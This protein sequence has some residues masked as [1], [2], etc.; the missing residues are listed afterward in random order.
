MR[1]AFTIGLLGAVLF[2]QGCSRSV[3]I[4]KA[5]SV[6]KEVDG[7]TYESIPKTTFCELHRSDFKEPDKMHGKIW[8]YRYKSGDLRVELGH[9]FDSQLVKVYHAGYYKN[10]RYHRKQVL[11]VLKP[12]LT[13]R[14]IEKVRGC[15]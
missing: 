11:K 9:A 7:E 3:A 12:Y 5:Y 2:L 6:T 8:K 10:Q 4:N 14:G 1:L 13:Q 15:I